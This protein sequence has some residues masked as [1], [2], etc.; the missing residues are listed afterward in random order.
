MTLAGLV[1][2]SDRK[3]YI[4]SSLICWYYCE[5]QPARTK[6]MSTSMDCDLDHKLNKIESTPRS[7]KLI[8]NYDV[9]KEE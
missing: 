1:T 3:F 8:L 9:K 2:F 7:S 4:F 6:K 5:F